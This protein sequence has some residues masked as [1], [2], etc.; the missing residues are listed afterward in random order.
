MMQLIQTQYILPSLEPP[1]G[2]G[3]GGAGSQYLIIA[4]C[5]PPTPAATFS[6]PVAKDILRRRGCVGVA[7][8]PVKFVVEALRRLVWTREQV[9]D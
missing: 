8:G 2:S 7:T 5:A 6:T 4:D 3:S 1:P 9:G